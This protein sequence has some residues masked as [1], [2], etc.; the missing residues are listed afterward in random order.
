M[1]GRLAET[2]AD[3]KLTCYKHEPFEPIPT[4]T[5]PPPAKTSALQ[6]GAGE[7]NG[8]SGANAVD[9]LVGHQLPHSW[10]L[11]H[12][13]MVD[14]EFGFHSDGL[15]LPDPSHRTCVQLFM[16]AGDGKQQQE[17]QTALT[18]I[19]A[20]KESIPD[21]E[22]VVAQTFDRLSSSLE[23]S[24]AASSS[25]AVPELELDATLV[26]QMI[27]GKAFGRSELQQLLSHVCSI[28][29]DV[30]ILESPPITSWLE[31]ALKQ[32]QQSAP[33]GM[34][35]LASSLLHQMIAQLTQLHVL[36]K[37][38]QLVVHRPAYLQVGAE[39][40]RQQVAAALQAGQ[41]KLDRTAPWLDA[42]WQSLGRPQLTKETMVQ[43]HREGMRSLLYQLALQNN[44]QLTAERLPEIL[45]LDTARIGKFRSDVRRLAVG[46][47]LETVATCVLKSV[48]VQ[49]TALESDH[50]QQDL[51]AALDAAT[52]SEGLAGAAASLLQL[53]AGDKLSKLP[54]VEQLVK[55][56]KTATSRR[57]TGN[58]RSLFTKRIAVAIVTVGPTSK[59]ALDTS[60]G[61]VSDYVCQIQAK[62]DKLCSHLESAYAHLY[63][64]LLSSEQQ[65]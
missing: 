57:Q 13:L 27:R 16:H 60:L 24:F 47:A 65:S 56:L 61:S 53:A 45:S 62:V 21:A 42:A 28:A 38:A 50:F 9:R 26:C 15:L 48:G 64:A 34:L 33:G 52:N 11:A 58:L 44:D 41:L 32:I 46:A 59:E 30:S 17:L 20:T 8:N 18:Q 51:L 54:D 49:L 6:A 25:A 22:S 4:L 14:D 1:N 55:A 10:Q 35:Q 23:A 43:A 37:N 39:Y 29:A 19:A 2:E 63:V 3:D 40:E 12:E 36:E 31:Q 7:G 5:L